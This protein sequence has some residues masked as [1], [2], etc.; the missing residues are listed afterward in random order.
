MCLQLMMQQVSQTL[1]GQQSVW[2]QFG[3]LCQ[4]GTIA[5]VWGQLPFS[6]AQSH[7]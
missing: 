4:D 3:L 7:L 2:V 5:C 1:K 6:A